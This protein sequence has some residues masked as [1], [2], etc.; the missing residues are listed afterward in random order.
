MQ[1]ASEDG[2]NIENLRPDKIVEMGFRSDP[3]I[4]IW[5]RN[6]HHEPMY[7]VAVGRNNDGDFVNN[8]DP[9]KEKIVWATK[10]SYTHALT[11]ISVL[12]VWP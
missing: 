8:Q 12:T 4:A 10:C 9:W 7:Y 6:V 11:N 1:L 2:I 3:N 5:L